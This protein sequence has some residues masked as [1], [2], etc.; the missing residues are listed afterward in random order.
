MTY[1]ATVVD[2]YPL[3]PRVSGFRLRVPGHTFEHR[4]GQHTTVRFDSGDERVVRPY[5]PTNLPGTDE[6]TFAIRRYDGGLA[7]SYMHTTRPGDEV[8][9]GELEGNLGI[10]DFGR[11]VAFLA[12]GTGITPM[13]AM[14]RQYLREGSGDAT[15]LFGEHDEDSLIH[16]GTL[17]ELAATYPA[18]DVEFT[19]SDPNWEW[20]GRAGYVQTHLDAL[21]ED[22]EGTDFY[23]CGVPG[24]VVDTTDRLAELGAPDERVHSEGWEQDAVGEE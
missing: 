5:T 8:T 10:D 9:I 17:N 22:F 4:P 19:L 11:D 16:R 12:T 7:S 3:T 6:L 14:L 15:L 18:L 24:M 13:L 20:T 21:F 1:T 2:R 23:V